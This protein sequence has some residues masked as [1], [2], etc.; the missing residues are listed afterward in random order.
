[1]D[2]GMEEAAE[3]LEGQ[4]ARR[5][6][7]RLAASIE[8]D[9]DIRIEV[10]RRFEAARDAVA[11]FHRVSL[12]GREGAGFIRYPDGGFYRSHR[13]RAAVRSWPDAARRRIALVVFLNSSNGEEPGEFSGGVLRLFG[14]DSP[15]DVHPIA[16]LL[17]AFPAGTLHEVTVVSGGT[18]DAIVDWFYDGSVMTP[19]VT[20]NSTARRQ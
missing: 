12:G 9:P 7:V 5:D 20:P 1:M 14:G 18:R 16:G 3:I 10:E 13:D 19:R 17:V 8:I 2:E 11:S 4:I 15:I 6:T